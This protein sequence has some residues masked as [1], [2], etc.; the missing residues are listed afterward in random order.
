MG[1]VPGPLRT[2]GRE[3]YPAP[4]MLRA[5]KHLTASVAGLFLAAAAPPGASAATATV[6]GDDGNPIALGG[7]VTIRN[8]APEVAVQAEPGDDHYRV[9]VLGPTGL[10]VTPTTCRTAR[11]SL[12]PLEVAYRGNGTYRVI[13]SVYRGPG[14]GCQGA[15]EVKELLFTIDA[16]AAVGPLPPQFLRRDAGSVA[17]RGLTV[18]VDYNPGATSVQVQY[19]AGVRLRPDGGLSGPFETTVVRSSAT[20]TASVSFPA[21]GR[22][23]FVARAAR[24]F[25]LFQ[26]YTAWS[27]PVAVDVLGP[28]D[29]K[30]FKVTDSRGPGYR[31]KATVREAGATG[32][33]AFALARRRRG[34]R[35]RSVGSARIARGRVV[36]KRFRQRRLGTYRLRMTYKGSPTVAPGQAVEVLRF[37]RRRGLR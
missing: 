23:L 34:G 25:G 26:R 29:I 5:G 20:P 22:Y 15:P 10:S 32:R 16:F 28:F 14:S 8:M 1:R 9:R 13:L 6:S 33:V 4:P 27:P 7:P 2:A 31:I 3:P 11:S 37:T 36:A 19:G 17:A 30:A 24:A 12:R 18:P 35:F 21:A